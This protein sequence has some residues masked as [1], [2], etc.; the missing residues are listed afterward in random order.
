MDP[1]S[2]P[3]QS[4]E[5]YRSTGQELSRQQKV[6]LYNSVSSL[7]HK[8]YINLPVDQQE[9][10]DRMG[11][12]SRKA[13]E[14]SQARKARKAR[15]AAADVEAIS[16][17][18]NQFKGREGAERRNLKELMKTTQQKTGLE[19]GIPLRIEFVDDYTDDETVG[20]DDGDKENVAPPGDEEAGE[21]GQDGVE[22]KEASGVDV[23]ESNGGGGT[24][25][26]R[27]GNRGG[28]NRGGGNRGH[29]NRGRGT[30][31]RGNR[32]SRGRGGRGRGTGGRG[33]GGEIGQ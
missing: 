30:W 19:P 29:G 10:V 16:Q 23:W 18:V 9:M 33:R 31:H 26:G 6:E 25:G 28:G 12:E 3:E 13:S 1:E 22:M 11:E 14:A 32:G 8:V 7:F 17:V 2:S 20:A 27:G 4:P 21:D 24:R 5:R 15:K